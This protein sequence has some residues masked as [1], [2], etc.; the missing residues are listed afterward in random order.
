MPTGGVDH[1]NSS[2]KTGRTPIRGPVDNKGRM[3]L[4]EHH[5]AQQVS[6]DHLFGCCDR[7]ALALEALEEAI[8]R[9]CRLTP[10]DPVSS[11][12][13]VRRCLDERR[14]RL[15]GNGC[16]K[17][18]TRLHYVIDTSFIWRAGHPLHRMPPVSNPVALMVHERSRD[19]ELARLLQSRQDPRFP[20]RLNDVPRRS[21]N[22]VTK[23]PRQTPPAGQQ[24]RGSYATE[25]SGCL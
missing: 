4:G 16:L 6:V 18:Q 24:L 19:T 15:R 25:C 11:T 7:P 22:N 3:S 13:R 20:G 9:W 14:T 17:R 12:P 10:G 8:G 1:C 21:E 23:P 5:I 2:A